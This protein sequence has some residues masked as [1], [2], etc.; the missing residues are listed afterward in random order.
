[1]PRMRIHFT[2]ADLVRT[3]LKLER[4]LMWEV[5]SSVQV[6]QH[7]EGRV[8]FDPW[9]RAVRERVRRDPRVRA[10]VRAL[11]AVAPHAAYFPDFLTPAQDQSGIGAGVEAVLATPVERV[12]AEVASIR[13][14]GAGA[15]RWLGGL[16]GGRVEAYRCLERALRVFHDVLL[17]PRLPVVDSALRAE[18]VAG[19]HHYLRGGPEALLRW[20]PGA[21]W[22]PPVLVV[23][24][25]V[26]RDLR[27]GG[28]GLVLIPSYFCVFHPVALA[29]PALPP[30]LV[31]PIRNSSRLLG[32]ERAGGDHVS[33]LLGAT[34]AAVLRAAVGGP[35]TGGLARRLGVSPA[36][37]S[38]H[39]GVLRDAGLVS[40]ERC[41]NSSVHRV[42][43][44]GMAV[45][46]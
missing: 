46:A 6:L 17:A 31:F 10:A 37:V 8:F 24:Y 41:G 15:A 9:R 32:V 3:R 42:T 44:L 26:D 23:D 20:L 11:V 18:C 14:G 2:D 27:L 12:R 29:D 45:L 4:D 21:R 1:M 35:T 13:V 19:S 25:P 33:A 38:H 43:A 39:T 36:T 22:E 40:T 34:R 28:R 30:V 16:A 7:S 5:V